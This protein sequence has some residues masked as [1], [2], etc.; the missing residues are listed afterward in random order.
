MR[1]MPPV[2]RKNPTRAPSSSSQYSLM[3]FMREFPDDEACL[4]LLFDGRGDLP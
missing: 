2:D 4:G 1:A 3:E